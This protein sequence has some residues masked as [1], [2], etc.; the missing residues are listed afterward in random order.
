M[1][2]AAAA[3]EDGRID[4]HLP[5]VAAYLT[6][7]ALGMTMEATGWFADGSP[8]AEQLVIEARR[9]QY[10]AARLRELAPRAAHDGH[11]A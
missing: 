2:L 5:H 11:R 3:L 8:A 7:V 9:L 6:G 10:T 4:D 1:D